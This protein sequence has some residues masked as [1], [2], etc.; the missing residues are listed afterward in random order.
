MAGMGQLRLLELFRVFVVEI[1]GFLLCH[2]NLALEFGVN[3]FLDGQVLANLLA[4][5]RLGEACLAKGL[6]KGLV[7]GKTLLVPFQL[8]VD[9]GAAYGDP[10]LFAFLAQQFELDHF[11]ENRLTE[12][13]HLGIGG[14]AP[15]C[16][17][18]TENPIY[19]PLHGRSSNGLAI[20]KSRDLLGLLYRLRPAA[21][22]KNKGSPKSERNKNGFM[23][24]SKLHDSSLYYEIFLVKRLT[25][26][27][28]R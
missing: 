19:F 22:C 18:T 11:I 15:L 23:K 7:I 17:K 6:G 24:F 25:K 8:V 20:Y 4:Q 10:G 9:I 21:G 26:A 27:R 16:L 3:E 1:L 2:L 12:R 13:G 28:L 14:L 5:H